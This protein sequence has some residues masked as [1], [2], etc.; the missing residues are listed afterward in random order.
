[1]RLWL[2]RMVGLVCVLLLMVAGAHQ[3]FVRYI[4]LEAQ[5]DAVALGRWIHFAYADSFVV[6][7]RPEGPVLR[8]VDNDPTRFLSRI[9]TQLVFFPIHKIQVFNRRGERVFSS[10]LKET[11]QPGHRDSPLVQALGGETASRLVKRVEGVTATGRVD[12]VETYLPLYD[13]RQE[14]VGAMEL[15]I[16]V[17]HYR[18]ETTRLAL[19]LGSVVMGCGM[20]L[21]AA[22][23]VLCRARKQRTDGQRMV[24]LC[25]SCHKIRDASGVWQTLEQFLSVRSGVGVTHS[26]CPGC[27]GED[28]LPKPG[29]LDADRNQYDSSQ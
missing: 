29:N 22:V 20:L 28:G 8:L 10:S 23:W 21:Y 26:Y 18:A 17:S 5:N 11:G 27:V 16:D 13:G 9:S 4:V 15:Y 12:L 2:Q 19:F 3:L 25:S 7:A 14:V 24:A 1:M 6:D